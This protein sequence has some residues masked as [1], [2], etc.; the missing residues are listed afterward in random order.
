M[1]IRCSH[2]N[3]DDWKPLGN[4]LYKCLHCGQEIKIIVVK[5]YD[6]N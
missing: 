2:C 3:S 4:N 5:M 6:G 1:E